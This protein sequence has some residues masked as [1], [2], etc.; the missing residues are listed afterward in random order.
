MARTKPRKKSLMS[1]RVGP[2]KGRGKSL[3]SLAMAQKRRRGVKKTRRRSN[4]R[5]ARQGTKK[6][7]TL[8]SS[9]LGSGRFMVGNTKT[10]YPKTGHSIYTQQGLRAFVKDIAGYH[11]GVN[12]VSNTYFKKV[13]GRR[14]SRAGLMSLLVDDSYLTYLNNRKTLSKTMYDNFSRNHGKRTSQGRLAHKKRKRRAK[15]L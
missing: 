2:R 3:K 4:I 11:Y 15:R 9:K 6:K 10:K 5:R 7:R 14:L 1:Q 12:R 8:G 13:G